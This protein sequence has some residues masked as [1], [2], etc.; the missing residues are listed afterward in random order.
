MN[1]DEIDAVLREL[2]EPEFRDFTSKL[3]PGTENV[4]GVRIPKLRAIAKQITKEDWREFLRYPSKSFEHTMV[5]AFVIATA[6]V[7]IDERL[8]LTDGFIP[9]VTNWAINDSFCNSWKSGRNDDPEKL[10]DYSLALVDRHEEFPSRVGAIMMM[11]HFIDD[12]HID[13]MLDKLV[14]CPR[15]GYYLDMGV[16]WALSFCYIKYPERTEKAIFDG[17]LEY[18]VLNMTVRKIRDSFRVSKE[19]KDRLKTRMKEVTRRSS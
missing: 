5:R 15:C 10:W 3:M 17:R 11:T 9:E 8:E 16:A 2:T 7:G 6:P 14:T 12:A 18:D 19:D 13:A 4:L 1:G